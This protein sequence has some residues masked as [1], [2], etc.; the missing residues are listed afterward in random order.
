MKV[1]IPVGILRDLRKINGNALSDVRL[2]LKMSKGGVVA[3]GHQPTLEVEA[4]G[5]K[6]P[7]LIDLI[8]V[9]LQ[10]Y[11]DGGQILKVC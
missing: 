5:Q 3:K 11:P 9:N 7:P 2:H 6:P 4:F 8:K 10:L 1:L